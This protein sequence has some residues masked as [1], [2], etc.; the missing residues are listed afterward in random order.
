MTVCYRPSHIWLCSVSLAVIFPSQTLKFGGHALDSVI[1]LGLHFLYESQSISVT[2]ETI[3]TAAASPWKLW[4]TGKKMLLC[5][6]EK[7]INEPQRGKQ[8]V[9]VTHTGAKQNTVWM[10]GRVEKGPEAS[11]GKINRKVMSEK[12]LH[13]FTSVQGLLYFCTATLKN[14]SGEYVAVLNNT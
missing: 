5:S 10:L 1:Y 6:S 7:Q 9:K 3:D 2:A 11:C 12:H 8:N 14:W 4:A 13:K